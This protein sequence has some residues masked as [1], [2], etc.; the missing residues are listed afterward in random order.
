MPCLPCLALPVAALSGGA[1]IS[2][3]NK[4]IIGVSLVITI[5]A[6]VWFIYYKYGAGECVECKIH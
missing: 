4:M 1:A 2:S 5:A 3:T 6:I